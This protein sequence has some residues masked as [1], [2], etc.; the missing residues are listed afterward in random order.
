M[1]TTTEINPKQKE[2]QGLMDEGQA[3]TYLGFKNR[4]SLRNLRCEGEGPKYVKMG[5]FIR[6]RRQDLDHY[7]E[8]KLRDPAA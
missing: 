2:F 4:N 5:R 7:V 8:G 1:K 3:A 6:Y